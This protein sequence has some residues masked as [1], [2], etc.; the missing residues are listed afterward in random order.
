MS[1]LAISY[2]V[3]CYVIAALAIALACPNDVSLVKRVDAFNVLGFLFAPIYV[4][5][6]LAIAILAGLCDLIA[7]LV[8]EARR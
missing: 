1:W 5:A 3:G 8:H 6:L 7:A 2:L 4:P